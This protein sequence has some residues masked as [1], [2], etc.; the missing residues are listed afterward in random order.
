MDSK[1]RTFELNDP[2]DVK[3]IHRSLFD[4]D[5]TEEE[6][7]GDQSDTNSGD[8]L[9]IRDQDSETEQNDVNSSFE[10]EN[11]DNDTYYI[12]YRKKNGR[13]VDSYRWNKRPHQAGRKKAKNSDN[14]TYY[15]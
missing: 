3:E 10:D 12:A 9:Q 15:T 14:D 8:D 6:N 2:N 1:K 4:Y 13:I 7:F 11:S 5:S